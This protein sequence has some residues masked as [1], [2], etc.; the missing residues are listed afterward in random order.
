M[1]CLLYLVEV[2]W[3]QLTETPALAAGKVG[4]RKR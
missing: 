1:G 4:Y 2:S 3:Y